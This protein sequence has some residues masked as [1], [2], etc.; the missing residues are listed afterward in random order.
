MIKKYQARKGSS[1]GNKD[2][3]LVG[4]RLNQLHSYYRGELTPQQVV[5]DA[6]GIKSPLHKFFEWDESSAAEKYRIDQ[7]RRLMGSIVEIIIIRGEKKESRSFFNVINKKGKHIYVTLD[8]ITKQPDY[9]QQLIIE[10]QRQ[11]G[12]LNDVLDMLVFQ[13]KK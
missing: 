12:R 5:Q 3:Q 9:L 11:I 6:G 8:K 10:S 13:L 2:A 1:L 4:T 7:A